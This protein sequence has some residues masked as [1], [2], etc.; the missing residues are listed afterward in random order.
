MTKWTDYI[1]GIPEECH[2]LALANLKYGQAMLTW[3]MLVMFFW[4]DLNEIEEAIGVPKTK[5]LKDKKIIEGISMHAKFQNFY[6]CDLG[7][8]GHSNY[9]AVEK[10]FKR[11]LGSRDILAHKVL[12]FG[13]VA[14]DTGEKSYKDSPY[15]WID[16]QLEVIELCQ[17][18]IDNTLD[19]LNRFSKIVKSE[20]I[21]SKKWRNSLP[22]SQ[23]DKS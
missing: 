3:G 7:W 17:K 15:Q 9:L 19:G 4:K 6:G 20:L 22:P 8:S 14:A 2:S 5:W 12:L 18:D 10:A 21:S 23:T 13:A 16:G 11:A 1:K